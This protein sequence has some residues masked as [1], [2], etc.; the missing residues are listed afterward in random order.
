MGTES[1]A[2]RFTDAQPTELVCSGSQYLAF[3]TWTTTANKECVSRNVTPEKSFQCEKLFLF[4]SKACNKTPY[5]C[6]RDLSSRLFCKSTWFTSESCIIKT[7]G[8][9]GEMETH[10]EIA[11]ASYAGEGEDEYDNEDDREGVTCDVGTPCNP[12]DTRFECEQV[13]H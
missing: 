6:S 9:W 13:L 11:P 2:D 10:L 1:P 8:W 7:L 5:K 4:R 3:P 12:A